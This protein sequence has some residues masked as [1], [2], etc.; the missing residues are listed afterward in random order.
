MPQ[1][2][3]KDLISRRLKTCENCEWCI[4]VCEFPRCLLNKEQKGLFETCDIFKQRTGMHIS[5]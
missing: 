4:P 3:E 5:M 1:V 2:E